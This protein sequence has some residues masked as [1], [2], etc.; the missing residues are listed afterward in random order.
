MDLSDVKPLSDRSD[1]LDELDLQEF[2]TGCPDKIRSELQRILSSRHF[3]ASE[4]NRRFLQYVVEETL[5]GRG[6]RIKAYN[7]A[8]LV[9]GRDDSFDP[10]LDP[11]VRM[12]ARRLRRSLER[13]YLVD[14]GMAG[15]QIAMPKGGYVPKFHGA[16]QPSDPTGVAAT[17]PPPR[18]RGP[19]IRIVPFEIED[20]C[21]GRARY[22]DG[23]ARQIAVGLSHFPEFSVFL[24]GSAGAPWTAREQPEGTPEADLI[25]GGDTALTAETLKVKATLLDRRTGRVVWGEAFEQDWRADGL[26][27][28][29]DAVADCIVRVVA[30][31]GGIVATAAA[32]TATDGKPASYDALLAFYRYRRSLRP[33]LY[34]IA[35]QQ[36]EHTALSD[37][38]FAEAM[39]CHSLLCSDGYRFGFMPIEAP[40]CLRERAI[41][42]ARSAVELAPISSRAHHA[43]GVAFWS[44]G[45]ADAALESLQMACTLNPNATEAMA[46]LGLHWCLRSEW[47]KG[48]PLIEAALGHGSVL[49]GLPRLGL[50]LFHFH[51]GGFEQA[52]AETRRIRANQLTSVLAA[53]AIALLR[54]GRAR[55]MAEAIERISDIDRHYWRH[56]LREFG[57]PCMDSALARTIGA[58]LAEAG[59]ARAP[60][61]GDEE[62]RLDEN[63]HTVGTA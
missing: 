58:A 15:L 25:L 45:D 18:F 9:F 2:E 61:Q 37:P 27:K 13:F 7:V 10:Q 3:D 40:S 38:D 21:P 34:R 41:G 22:A 17:L 55:E 35:W 54:L 31:P 53:Q 46:D 60:P 20:D 4:R 57:G 29:R 51:C 32:N 11:V 63:V 39:A 30:D 24:S 56:P 47:T 50:S 28:T 5:L 8:T 33:D 49:A 62:L 1:V 14:G 36:L 43:L 44:S 48:V 42:L 59:L 12:E 23:F 26:L 16:P 19:S 6:E 52:L